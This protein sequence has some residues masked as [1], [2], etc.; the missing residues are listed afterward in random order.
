M[1][2]KAPSVS[3]QRFEKEIAALEQLRHAGPGPEVE[4]ALQKALA[5]RNNYI[6]SKAARV[7]AD[8]RPHAAQ[9]RRGLG[10]GLDGG[11][12]GDGHAKN[13]EGGGRSPL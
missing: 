12:R 4:A 7:T 5:L 10:G 9:G 13:S 3:K 8:Q 6:V 11:G 2:K 1:A